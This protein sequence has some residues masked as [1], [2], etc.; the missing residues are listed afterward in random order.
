MSTKRKRESENKNLHE[1]NH[2]NDDN[3]DGGNEGNEE[4]NDEHKNSVIGIEDN[5]LENY[6]VKNFEEKDDYIRYK[7]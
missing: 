6:D 5:C 1:G 3:L 2:E 4:E 7:H